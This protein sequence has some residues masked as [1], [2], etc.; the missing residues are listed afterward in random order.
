MAS[1]RTPPLI[2]VWML[3]TWCFALPMAAVTWV[4]HR[5]MGGDPDRFS[6]RLGHNNARDDG[7]VVWFHAASLGEVMQ[8]GPLAGHLNQS[9]KINILVTTTTVTGANWVAREMP[10]ATHRFAPIDTP[11]AVRRFLDGWS[12]AAA[13]FVEGDLWPRML[14]GLQNRDVPQILINARHSRTRMRF[15]S[16]FAALLKP[17]AFVTCRSEA[18]ADSMRGLGLPSD[19]VHVL[20]DLRLTL[21]K[22]DVPQDAIAALSQAAQTRPIWLAASTHRTDE[23]HVLNAHLHGL[24][25][26]PDALLV[27]APRHTD[28]G[29]PLMKL[30]QSKGLKAAQRSRKEPVT[31]ATQVYVADTMGELGAFFK[32]APVAFIGGSFGQEGGHNPYEPA[33]FDTGIVYGPNVKNFIDAY[34][35]L[36][37]AGAA[38]QVD[39]PKQLGQVIVDLMRGDKVATMGEAGRT[40]MANSQ[41]C[42]LDYAKLIAGV[43]KRP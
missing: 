23:D 33:H 10:Y 17:F 37:H 16:V 8:I 19:K 35:S 42:T 31:Q 28:R 26:F 41:N 30:A 14:K 7:S 20:P 9:E 24:K 2:H 36:R 25:T 13:V 43:L 39:D 1:E 11:G 38:Q 6:E 22:L 5:R 34:A 32:L 21:P 3:L 40:Y 18:V 15:H 27:I 4:L 29:S 12:I